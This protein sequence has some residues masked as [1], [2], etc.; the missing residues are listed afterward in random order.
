ML[1]FFKE[2]VV[3][4]SY[5]VSVKDFMENHFYEANVF[6]KE[7]DVYVRS[8]ITNGYITSVISVPLLPTEIHLDFNEKDNVAKVL[9][10][11]AKEDTNE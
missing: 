3:Q 4:K 6:G 1:E 11:Y 10:R 9:R 8:S 2:V 5:K 7:L